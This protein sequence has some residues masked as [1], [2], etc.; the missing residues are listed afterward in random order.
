[1]ILLSNLSIV[2]PDSSQESKALDPDT[3]TSIPSSEV[4]AEE[5][6]FGNAVEATE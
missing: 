3:N 5:I 2:G 4:S 6:P 1:L